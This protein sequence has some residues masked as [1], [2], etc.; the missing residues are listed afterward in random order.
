MY[1]RA[2]LT[3]IRSE[4]EDGKRESVAVFTAVRVFLYGFVSPFVVSAKGLFLLWLGAFLET[5][6][7][8]IREGE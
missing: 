3:M 4:S 6:C 8:R 2:E 1:F 5:R 7:P